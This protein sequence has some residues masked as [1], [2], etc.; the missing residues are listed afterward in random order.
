MFSWFCATSGVCWQGL[1]GKGYLFVKASSGNSEV[2]FYKGF[3]G[4][5]SR[6]PK[7]FFMDLFTF[8]AT[9]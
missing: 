5:S 8:N 7:F 3:L 6:D 1:F 9:A 2:C 4:F